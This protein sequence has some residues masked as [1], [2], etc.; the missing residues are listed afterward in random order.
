VYAAAKR[1]IRQTMTGLTDA[2][3]SMQ[4]FRGRKSLILYSEGFIKSPSMPDYQRAIELAQQAHVTVYVIDPR[5]LGTG[6]AMFDGESSPTM[7][8]LDTNAGGSTYV[9]TAT[10][11]RVSTS[12]DATALFHAA[13][14]ESTAY[15]LIGFQPAP[16]DSGERKLKIKVRG[17]GLKV[18]APD[19]YFVG[20]P[21]AMASPVPGAVRALGQATDATDIALR[22]GTLF[23]GTL[24]NGQPTTTV[25]VEVPPVPGDTAERQ[26]TLLIEARPLGKGDPVRDT[27]DL[28][29]PPSQAPVVVTRELHLK[30]GMWQARVVLRDPRTEKLGSVLHTFQVPDA[31]GLR[32]SSPI[33]SNALERS[34]VPH[35]QIRLDRRFLPTDALYCQYHV[36]GAAPDPT[37]HRPR[38]T[39]SYAI[40]RDGQAV[41]EGAASPI[42]PTADGEVQRLIGFKL[43]GF[44][45]GDYVLVLGV[46]DQVSGQSRQVREAFS[47]GG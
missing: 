27:A 44:P 21:S 1:R 38:V 39:G 15:Y 46:I 14:V 35:A 10:G 6:A 23:L 7:V 40:L 30:P 16:G 34:Q 33:L 11:G 13:A 20:E 29:L 45:A 17:D 12:N 32:V 42:D 2:V 19:R 26:L 41:Q 28:T 3:A 9:A 43:A 36:F 8:D 47:I 5:G 22:A 24:A 4:P 18:R 25:A 31:T 37:T